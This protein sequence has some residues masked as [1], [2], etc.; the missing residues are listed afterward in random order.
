MRY[1]EFIVL[2]SDISVVCLELYD[3]SVVCLEL[4]DFILEGREECIFLLNGIL[5]VFIIW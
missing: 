3:L 4:Y 2:F 5:L 1:F